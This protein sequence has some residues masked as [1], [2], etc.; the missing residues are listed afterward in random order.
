MT[1]WLESADNEVIVSE[2][3]M[4]CETWRALKEYIICYIYILYNNIC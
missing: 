1:E 4:L 2:V 3:I